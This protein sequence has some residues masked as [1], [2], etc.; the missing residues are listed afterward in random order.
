VCYFLF[1]F[2][3]IMKTLKFL[4][5]AMM[6]MAVAFGAYAQQNKKA[7]TNK[8]TG[9]T[10]VYSVQ[11]PDANMSVNIELKFES[12]AKCRMTTTVNSASTSVEM[13]YSYSKSVVTILVASATNGQQPD[14][15][16][17]IKDNA[18]NLNVGTGTILI[19]NKQ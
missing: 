15:T 18:L 10:W 17:E 1:N 6:S 7:S 14:W 2:I 3:K 12:D 11:A 13:D 8:M 4:L 5:V 9:T 19:F 16:G